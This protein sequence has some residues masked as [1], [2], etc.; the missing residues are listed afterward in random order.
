[1][2]PQGM[3]VGDN[4]LAII[5]AAIAFY[6]I[7]FI[8]YGAVFSKLWM[9][10]SGYTQEQLKPHMWK[11]VRVPYHLPAVDQAFAALLDDLAQS[12][13]L[14]R[15]LVVYFTEFGRTP[16]INPQGGRDHWGYSGSIFFAGGGVRGG[17]VI[18]QTDEI[19]GFC[20][21]RTYSPAE[22]VATVYKSVGINPHEMIQDREGRPRS[23]QPWG[24]SIPVF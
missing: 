8:I 3:I 9:Q 2:P 4:W 17:Q 11:M 7:G 10:V 16:K 5:V 21:T 24:E 6:A 1:M 12:G 18:G 23:I 13:R 20:K 19:G 15:T 14:E 22:A